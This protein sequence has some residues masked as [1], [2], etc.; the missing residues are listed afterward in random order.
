MTT[1]VTVEFRGLREL[2]EALRKV[3]WEVQE[4]LAKTS[5]KAG[6]KV[7]QDRA[8]LL[9]PKDTGT[10]KKSIIIYRDKKACRPGIEMWALTVRS[11]KTKRKKG[12]T[13]PVLKGRADPNNAFYWKFVEFGTVKMDAQAFMF[14]AFDAETA[15]GNESP[16][17]EAVRD[18][19]KTGIEKINLPKLAPTGRAK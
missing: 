13:S 17:A 6:I 14:P 15:A 16:A 3:T 18:K 12:D 19:L 5:V 1:K 11:K 2:G 8:I 7:I 10:L 9:A 4:K